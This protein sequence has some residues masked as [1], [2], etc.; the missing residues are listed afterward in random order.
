MRAAFLINQANELYIMKLS[1]QLIQWNS[2]FQ[3]SK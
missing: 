2:W 1:V 3:G